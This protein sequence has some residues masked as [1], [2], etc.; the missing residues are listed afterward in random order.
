MLPVIVTINPDGGAIVRAPKV[1]I[2]SDPPRNGTPV[3]AGSPVG[4]LT[5]LRHRFLLVIPEGVAGRVELAERHDDVTPVA[6]GG[7]LFRVV[8]TGVPDAAVA[9]GVPRSTAQGASGL[10][11][12]APTDGVFY[13]SPAQGARPYVVVGDRIVAGQ[14]VGLIE[15]MKTFNPI[16]YGGGDLPDEAEVV[17]LAAEDEAEVRAG[18]P[19]MIVKTL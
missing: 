9:T 5:Q 13:R 15:V 11:V 3:A 10:R 12:L 7:I 1:G 4:R 17:A 14:A 2:W 16:L 19:L 6:Y 18:Q 8:N